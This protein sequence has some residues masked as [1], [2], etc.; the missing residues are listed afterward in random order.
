MSTQEVITNEPL[1]E[2][3]VRAAFLNR[4]KKRVPFEESIEGLEQLDGQLAIQELSAAATTHV[5]LLAKQRDGEADE[6]L[7]LAGIV[8]KALVLR[9]T[10]NRIFKDTDI[11]A[12][13]EFGLSILKPLSEKIAEVSGISPDALTNAK[14]N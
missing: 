8:A 14:K 2:E 10:H 7:M 6:A 1:N 12:V 5:E 3:Q 13:S 9:R 4:P 11:Q